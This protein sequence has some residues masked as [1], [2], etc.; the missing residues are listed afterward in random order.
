VATPWA[1]WHVAHTWHALGCPSCLVYASGCNPEAGYR[2]CMG[3][4]FMTPQ[5]WRVC[6]VQVEHIRA[7]CP[8]GRGFGWKVRHSRLTLVIGTIVRM[9]GPG[10]GEVPAERQ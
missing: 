2:R 3:L 10:S 4:C 9:H 5:R 6:A 7:D 8:S 1:P